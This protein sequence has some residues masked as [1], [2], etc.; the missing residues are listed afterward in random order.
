MEDKNE[1]FEKEDIGKE[2]G[3]KSINI[4]NNR[5]ELE[6]NIEI[7]KKEIQK[8]NNNKGLIINNS[9]NEKQEILEALLEDKS[10]ESFIFNGKLF[11]INKKNSRYINKDN[12]KRIIYK[13]SYNRHEEKFR[14]SLSQKS[15][16]NATIENIARNQG[17]KRGYLKKSPIQ[18][19]VKRRI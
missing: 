10:E 5:K 1:E 3:L 12:I 14:Q 6:K 4:N 15:F 17:I 13:C 9:D 8:E 7:A 18:L 19:N 16:C 11:K 2:I